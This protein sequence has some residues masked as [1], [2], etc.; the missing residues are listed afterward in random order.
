MK[1]VMMALITALILQTSGLVFAAE[2]GWPIELNVDEGQIIVYEPQPDGLEGNIL[3]GRAA[4]S[5]QP[6]GASE[7]AFGAVWFDSQVDIDRYNRMV[8]IDGMD[9]E[10]I[11]IT[12]ATTEQEQEVVSILE[13]EISDLETTLDYDNF[14]AGLTALDQEK[15]SV[16]G[17]NNDPPTILFETEPAILV[18]CDGEPE[19]RQMGS[20]GLMRVVNTP[21][22]IV[23]DPGTRS[24]W[25]NGGTYWFSATDIKGQW[26]A[27]SNPPKNVNS[28]YQAELKAT[29]GVEIEPDSTNTTVVPKIIVATEPTELIVSI[30]EPRFAQLPGSLLLYMTNT[31]DD[32]FM[33]VKSQSYYVVLSG[34]WYQGPSMDGPWEYVPSDQLP[35]E[36]A[37]IPGDSEKS[38]VLPF[39]AGTPEAEDAVMDASVPQT[40]AIK[41]SEAVFEA[42]YDGEPDFE[43]IPQTDIRAAR[44]TYQSILYIDGRYYACDEAVW[45]V[46]DSPQGPW[47]VSD[48]VPANVQ[49]I[50][51][52]SRYYHVR[53][54]HVYHSTP[55][56]VYVGY[57][58][59][60]LG[61]Y[62]Y[63]GTVVYGTGY[64]YRPYVSRRVYYPRPA[65]WGFHTNYNPWTGW[66]FGM[67]WSVGWTNFSIGF[68]H[69]Y[70]YDEGYY[71]GYDDGYDDGYRR[72]RRHGHRGWWGPGGYRWRPNHNYRQR[73]VRIHRPFSILDGDM[74][75]R[76]RINKN[77][78]VNLRP[79]DPNDLMGLYRSGDYR[80]AV[81]D[82]GDLDRMQ[83]RR[84]KRDYKA[85]RGPNNIRTD[86]DGRILKYD[87]KGRWQERNR[88]TWKPLASER[89]PVTA[90]GLT[91]GG[92]RPVTRPDW[93][94]IGKPPVTTPGLTPGDQ[95]PGTKPDWKPIDKPPVTSPGLTPG[96][97]GPGT[98]PDWKPIDKPPV[99]S[100]G[101][102]PGDKGPGTKPDWK[103]I[104]KPPVTS[105]GLTPGDK[106]PGTKPD[107]KPIDKPPVTSPG[108]TPGDKGPG[109]KPDWKPI[110]KP[111]V[112]SPG[113]TPGDKGPGAKPDWKPID[114]PPVTKPGLTPGDQRPGTKPDW[115][116]IDKPPVTSPGL[117][118]G[119]KPTVTKPDRKPSV[120]PKVTQPERVQPKVTQPERV[121]PRVTQP[122]RVQPKV[123]QPER[124]QPRVTQ[125][126]SVQPR[127]TQ[128]ERVQPK[129]TQPERVQPKVTQP[130]RVQPKVTQPERVQPRV[131]QPERV[132]PRVTQPERVQPKVTQ[133][134]RKPSVQPKVLPPEEKKAP[135]VSKGNQG[136]ADGD[137]GGQRK[138]K[139][140]EILIKPEDLTG[141]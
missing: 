131:T 85:G 32:V 33:D 107:W 2:I 31:E 17:L 73:P 49:Y 110:D 92:R 61:S 106:G 24:Y 128:P 79:E 134:E 11:R 71:D 1:Q 137:G 123:T 9:V 35:Q 56:V 90:P 80:R 22:F 105:P 30:G 129:V 133:P 18:V 119:D 43:P 4:V 74:D 130:E 23:L 6:N 88:G 27:K 8:Y 51:P 3:K 20:T 72:G 101:L 64:Y 16:E 40:A 121:Q 91:P 42:V 95:R 124:V 53:Y 13:R 96:D 94:P 98:K 118:P 37:N 93:K 112:T 19:L 5:F 28:A 45:F 136:Q 50:P 120:Q 55:E 86:R 48:L 117:T 83:G 69:G 125:P 15:A 47:Y 70:G 52:I 139:P 44:N 41:R 60:Y 54:V 77:N 97:K 122:E 62:P 39:I 14:V 26:Q 78:R 132:Q 57:T 115:K 25:L 59:G 89:T 103:P 81:L 87:D 82:R 109:T 141:N 46:A 140:G 21:F 126:E 84:D 29:G 111:P 99:T 58:P 104:D 100:P 75:Y 66:S 7:P 68:G 76:D 34:R 12:D 138:P 102:T 65:T 127:V 67:S 108:L 113:L 135:D 63:R 116:P 38:K 10:T 36:F 114:K